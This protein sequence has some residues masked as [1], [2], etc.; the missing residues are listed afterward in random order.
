[1]QLLLR[2]RGC[3][4][5]R[6]PLAW[7]RDACISK[8]VITTAASLLTE[9]SKISPN[10]LAIPLDE[11]ARNDDGI[12]VASPGDQR[13]RSDRVVERCHRQRIAGDKDEVSLLARGDTS[14]LVLETTETCT[15]HGGKPKHL[16]R[17]E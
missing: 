15:S 6:H 16:A 10:K 5:R 13:N 17:R 8:D 1:M 9:A 3:V 7:N 4:G 11:F 2:M 12:N 14:N